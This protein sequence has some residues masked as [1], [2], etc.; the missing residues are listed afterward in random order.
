MK[1]EMT[2]ENRTNNNGRYSIFRL[3]IQIPGIRY[4]DIARITK[5]NNGVISHFLCVL[6]KNYYIKVV[7]CSN[8]NIA[9]YFS[10]SISYEDCLI[11]GYLK[12]E[13]ARKIVL[14]L[15]YNSESNF[16]K[17]RLNINKASSTTSWNLKRLIDDDIIV[18]SRAKNHQYYFIKN[19][20]QVAKFLQ[21][22]TNLL[23]DGDTDVMKLS[24][25]V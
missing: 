15:H 5:F 16:E 10:S 20:S 23:L 4:N 12:N 9:R 1:T 25:T 8:G 22:S 3:I 14:F 11:I 2:L 19:P 6:K 7:R 13:T 17:I 24:V 18:K 21:N